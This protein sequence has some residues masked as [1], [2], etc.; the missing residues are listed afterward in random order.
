MSASV[1]SE[2]APRLARPWGRLVV[3]L[4][5]VLVGAV[6]T[7]TPFASLAVLVLL[8][9]TA[10]ALTGIGELTAARSGRS[11]AAARITG[12]G[13]VTAAT[14]VALWPGP[15]LQVLAVVAGL[16]MALAGA[17]RVAAAL[18]GT[19]DAR[20]ASAL[21]GGAGLLLGAL[22]LVWPDVTVFVVAV[23]FGVRTVL[24]GVGLVWA[25]L[26]GAPDVDPETRTAGTARRFVRTLGAIMAL[27]VALLLVT[28]S[29]TLRQGTPVADDFYDPP[30][31]VPA[32]P[33]VLLASEPFTRDVPDGAL[34]WRILYTTTRDQGQ[35]AVASAL[36]VAPLAASTEP[37]PI[38][39]W[40][41]GTTGVVPGCAPSVLEHP[42]EAGATP[43]LPQV[44]DNGWVMVAT[45]YVGLGTESPHP[46][47]IGQAEGRSVLDSVRAARQLR[48]VVWADGTV[49]W[50]HSQGGHAALWAG[51]LASD[52]APDAGVVGVSAMAPASNLPGLVDNLDVVPGGTLFAS[53][54]V[55]AYSAV[56]DD[57]S[58][59]DIVRPAARV[60][61][62]EIAGRCLAEPGALVSVIETFLFGDTIFTD[63]AKTGAFVDRLAENVPSG[64]ID[65]PLLL[66]QG[67]A[68]PLVLPAAQQAYVDQRCADGHEL[69]YRTYPDEDHL[70][71]VADES[72]LVG[73]LLTWT[74]ER[75]AGT[76]AESTCRD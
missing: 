43:A 48:D 65:A 55:E 3:G 36:V 42:F 38:V 5:L 52:Y 57:V 56:Y 47:L 9:I 30:D 70:S 69:D 60:Q 53:Y 74:E 58:F 2:S 11:R 17:L 6:L 67:D 64:A 46:Y 20:L 41:H 54:I 8:V 21:L 66:A 76:P 28:V 75:F 26:R 51:V 16:A 37:R 23:L 12:L 18:R 29:V 59:D 71:I 73:E 40:A 62:K 14:V 35:P 45:D 4:L 10:M 61:V 63:D 68:D 22:A 15:T 32:E 49:V 31:D 39:A 72:A 50:G 34:A 19:V 25:A 7:V 13:W 33:G 44:V 24:A 1:V 27:A